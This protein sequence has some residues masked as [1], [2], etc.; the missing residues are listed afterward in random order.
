M[1]EYI[2]ETPVLTR[3]I[4]RS[5]K[6]SIPFTG[7]GRRPREPSTTQVGWGTSDKTGIEWIEEE[8][9][10]ENIDIENVINILKYDISQLENIGDLCNT[11]RVPNT[12]QVR[13]IEEF[14]LNELREEGRSWFYFPIILV[15]L[16]M[17]YFTIL[18][19]VM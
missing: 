16:G 18:Y 8:C 3:A 6:R 10:R 14:I 7:E 11:L 13:E 4:R 9:R 1:G 15:I 17:F 12:K 2:P 19:L 5:D